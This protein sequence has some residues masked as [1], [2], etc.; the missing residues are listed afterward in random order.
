MTTSDQPQL[1]M[2]YPRARLS[3]PPPINLPTGYR[4]RLFTRGDEA[5]F[6]EVMALSGWAGWDAARLQPTLER[7]LP[8]GWF[9]A[10]HQATDQIV[11]SAMSLHNYHALHPFGGEIGWIA[12][13]PAHRGRAL[14]YAVCAVGNI[15]LMRR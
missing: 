13:D 7:V 10:V 11:A 9:F 15:Q 8:A 3:D 12:S 1:H 5:R 4:L 14:G 2:I 6:Y